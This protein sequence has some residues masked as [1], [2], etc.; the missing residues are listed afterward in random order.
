VAEIK[1]SLFDGKVDG[2]VIEADGPCLCLIKEGLSDRIP[3]L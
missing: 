2:D 3:R 1:R